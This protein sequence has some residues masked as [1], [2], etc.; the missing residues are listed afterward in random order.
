[1]PTISHLQGLLGRSLFQ[2][3]IAAM[4]LA[5]LLLVR[6][7]RR[8]GRLGGAA[9]VAGLAL[10]V[11]VA[12]ALALTLRPIADGLTVRTLHLDPI[13][14]AW[15]WDSVAWNP[16]I[17]NIALFVPIGALAAALWWRRS[18]FAVWI[19]CVALSVAIETTQFLIPTGRVAN[20][21]DVLANGT[22]A[23]LGILMAVLVGVRIGPD[24][25]GS[26][27]RRRELVSR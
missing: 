1:M 12:A 13:E 26:W 11:S 18:S 3:L 9:A 2:L 14:G 19:G 8:R 5:G 15:G 25:I 21:A 17:D 27:P 24:R 7:L 4:L 6:A 23:L 22:G 20:M 16:I 10:G